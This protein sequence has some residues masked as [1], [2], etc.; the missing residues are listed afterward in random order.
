MSDSKKI[1]FDSVLKN[2]AGILGKNNV[3]R[4]KTLV[5]RDVY[6]RI[7]ILFDFDDNDKEKAQQ[8][9][10]FQ[11]LEEDL[12]SLRP[13]S[14][15]TGLVLCKCDLV[16]LEHIFDDPDILELWQDGLSVR[17]L[18]RQI[19]GHDWLR[20]KLELRD[21]PI[22]RLAFYGFKGGVGRSTTIAALAFLLARSGKKI[23]VF[24]FDLESPGLS[25]MLL[26]AENY[27]IFGSV[28]WLVED[29]VDNVDDF[30]L[31]NVVASSP[32]ATNLEGNIRIVPAMG[33]KIDE[34]RIDPYYISKL[35]RIYADKPSRNGGTE[36][37]SDRLECLVETIEAREQPDVV[38]I[39]CRAGL[40]DLSA[41]SIVR[42][43]DEAFLFIVNTS[44]SWEGYHMLF[45]HWKQCPELLVK[46]RDKLNIVHAMKPI[47][48]R[49]E[50]K[51]EFIESSHLLFTDTI[52]EQSDPAIIDL[53][54]EEPYNFSK[55][56]L[57]A[58]HYPVDVFWSSSLSEF[59]YCSF[60]EKPI[61]DIVERTYMPIFE[62]VEQ[63][64][65]G[66]ANE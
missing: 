51:M 9:G 1:R 11:K 10:F 4:D 62:K 57:E 46:I 41:G 2:V 12:S 26:P 63:I 58:P 39:D 21:N 64:I 30:L 55:D 20:P 50:Q 28:D 17:L 43:T 7:F 3:Q 33:A 66:Y 36:R 52:Y 40:H 54:G 53:D 25:S 19:V 15:D 8:S 22:P 34:P 29:A 32:L 16:G 18:E 48:D 23:L 13:Y 49:A 6:G 35:S 60:E 56:A 65:Q 31:R 45:S 37:F 27:P 47:N 38:L 24:D 14:S 59:D 61:L 5:V 44:Q 42:I